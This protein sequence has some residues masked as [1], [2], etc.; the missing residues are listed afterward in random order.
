LKK[1]VLGPS[2]AECFVNAGREFECQTVSRMTDITIRDVC[3]ATID[4]TLK[5]AGAFQG[6][7]ESFDPTEEKKTQFRNAAAAWV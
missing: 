6:T 1:I 3:L 7:M 2:T 5:R 4:Q